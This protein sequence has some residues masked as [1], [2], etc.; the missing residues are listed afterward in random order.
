LKWIIE[1]VPCRL[2]KRYAEIAKRRNNN[3]KMILLNILM[4][5]S[6]LLSAHAGELDLPKV[7]HYGLNV[8]FLLK[9]NRIHVDAA[10][11]IRNVTDS[12][13]HDIPF[14]LYRLLSVKLITDQFGNP[15]Q[16]EQKVVQLSDEPSLQVKAI[17]VKLRKTLLPEDTL[18]LKFS[19][20]G[21]IFGYPEVM[22]YVRDK[23][24]ETYSLLRPDALAYPM[25]A[26]PS[27]SSNIASYDTKF[28][29]EIQ[30]TVPKGYTPVCGGELRNFVSNGLDSTL[31]TFD[32]KVPTWRID[33]AVAKFNVLEDSVHKLSVCYL[34][35]DSSGARRVL[36]T[37]RK[38][39]NFYSETF[40]W[41]KHYRGYTVI[42]IPDGWGSQA[43]DFYFLQTAPAFKDS[44]RIGEVYHEIGHSWNVPS[45]TSVQRCRYFDEA[46]AS[47]FQSLATRAL[48]D[49]QTF[50]KNLEMYRAHFAQAAKD[51]RRAFDTPIAKYGM[52]QLGGLSY[53]KGAWSLYVLNQLVGDK[54][55][56]QI[57][58]SMIAEYHDKAIDFTK[59][60]ALCERTSRKS[61]K[62][63][64]DE[65]MYGTESSKLL[66]DNTPITYIVKR[67]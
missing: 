12:A 16:F 30:A 60:Q 51:D 40:G 50:H 45:A 21:F 3:M 29:Y 15:L 1:V 65:W 64:F 59:F 11:T 18:N 23:I 39:I 35:E 9:D 26:E 2:P 28:T 4:G 48:Q 56:A 46:F 34:P 41:P 58:R 32:S 27:Y 44:S 25:L 7:I 20:E 43:G 52:E 49:D 67:Y 55:F 17:V 14:L 22:G 33:L 47:Y 63:Y 37:S 53:T 24:D 13:R 36:G 8:Q 31:F 66:V 38:V 19:Y 62:K 5:T 54:V 42:E 61:M 10:I 6:I 57:I